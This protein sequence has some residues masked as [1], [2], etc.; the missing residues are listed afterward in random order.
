MHDGTIGITTK[1]G[2]AGHQQSEA[3]LPSSLTPASVADDGCDGGFF[4]GRRNEDFALLELPRWERTARE[5]RF[6]AYTSRLERELIVYA[7]GLTSHPTTALDIGCEA[8]R[9][10]QIL[11]ALGWS[12]ICADID[13]QALELCQRRIPSARCVV[14]K[15]DN[16]ELPCDDKSL[17][18]L[19]C[20]ECPVMATQWF[21]E[22]A[23]RALKLGGVLVGVFHNKLSWRGALAHTLAALR[24]RREFWYSDSYP[25]WCQ[26]MRTRGFNIVREIGL[27]WPPFYHTS[28][29]RL[30][31]LALTA[32]RM[33]GL[34]KLTALSPMVAFVAVKEK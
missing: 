33:I 21:A 20:M 22:E 31:P 6:I 5:S 18:M 19:L 25:S 10:S 30:L 11:V 29:S 23:T 14:L 27:R 32:E 16:C 26:G 12:M 34:Q 2:S 8:G 9:F 1:L 15:E 28:N 13:R 3:A 4:A 17:A 7:A 24:G